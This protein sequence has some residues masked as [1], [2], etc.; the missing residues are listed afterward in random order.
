MIEKFQEHIKNKFPQI[1][2]ALGNDLSTR[3]LIACSG[4]V[5]SVL[6][7]HLLHRLE[8]DIAIAHCN[9]SLRGNESDEDAAFVENFA[10]KLNVPFYTETFDTKSFAKDN[11]LSTQVAARELRYS[12]FFELIET[13]NYSFVATGHHADDNLETFLINLSRSTGL[14]GLTGIP[15]IN[16]KIIRPLLPFSRQEILNYAKKEQLFWR[17][18]SSNKKTDYLRNKIRLEVIPSY[19]ETNKT[20]LK[21]FKKTQE[22]LQESQLL[23]DDYM[24]LVF[25][26][27]VDEM[28][29][30]Y[31][32]KIDKLEQLPN[33]KALLYE[34]LHP[35]GFTDFKAIVKLNKAQSGKA[36]FSNTHRLL[37]DRTMFILSKMDQKAEI[38]E[39]FIKKN[40]KSISQ[41]IPLSFMPSEIMGNIDATS[42]YV[43]A[44]LLHYP[45]SL[46]KWLEG[47]VFKPFGMK[48]NKKLS[49]FF[50]DE[51]LSLT[52]KEKIWLLESDKKI[53]WIIGLRAD[54]RFRVTDQTKEIL[55]ITTH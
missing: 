38:S 6:L 23:I 53:V 37:K 3:I 11:A 39:V 1:S 8:F 48:G 21:N 5:D 45:L 35:F 36:I 52:E 54:D 16:E 7:A 43:D 17:E 9:F 30:G 41:P 33:N 46:R 4:G 32:I 14:R 15:E 24:A 26:L 12:W 10:N 18:D 49:K 51:K 22:H 40:T 31:A 28:E 2:P 34:L 44:K 13:F 47:D 25:N 55:K 42:I 27:V 20:L 50:K 29:E 19:K